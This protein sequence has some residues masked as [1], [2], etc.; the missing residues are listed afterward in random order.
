MFKFWS[1]K[2]RYS[3]QNAGFGI[4][5]N[6]SRSKSGFNESG[7]ETLTAGMFWGLNALDVR[8]GLVFLFTE[9]RFLVFK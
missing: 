8:I 3:A 9:M 2:P 7:S 4:G 5:I 1:S 6:E